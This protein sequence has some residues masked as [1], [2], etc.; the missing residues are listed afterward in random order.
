MVSLL[1]LVIA[2]YFWRFS[3]RIKESGRFPPPGVTVLRDTRVLTG[4]AA[5]AQM[6]IWKFLAIGFG[7]IGV[8]IPLVLWSV[9]QAI[10]GR[11]GIGAP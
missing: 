1:I 9:A 8:A 10:V 11:P 6:R 3:N 4:K 5:L 7:V 2:V